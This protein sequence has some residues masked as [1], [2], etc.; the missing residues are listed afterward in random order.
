MSNMAPDVLYLKFDTC[1]KLYGYLTNAQVLRT[2][3]GKLGLGKIRFFTVALLRA[4]PC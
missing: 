1:M 3:P 2:R 4:L